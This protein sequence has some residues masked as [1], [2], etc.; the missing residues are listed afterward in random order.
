MSRVLFKGE[1]VETAGDLPAEGSLAKD[2]SLLKSD[3]SEATLDSYKGK[4]KLLNIFPSL[5]T[6]VCAATVKTF[7]QKLKDQDDVVV[8]NISKDLPF[9]QQR[10][11]Q[12]EGIKHAETLSA[13]RSSFAKDY[14][15]EMRTGDLKGLCSRNV[16]IL[17]EN[18]R[19]I[20]A[21]QVP[22]ITQEPDYDRALQI[23]GF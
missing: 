23:L 19:I 3:F 5:D 6:G 9:A 1:P 21:E 12:S 15:V 18:N 16:L 14:G 10:F 17:D 7:H 22:E 11:C 4:K 20:Y 8:L 2:F 13:F